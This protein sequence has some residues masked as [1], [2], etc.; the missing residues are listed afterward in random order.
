[1]TWPSAL[2]PAAVLA[3][4]LAGPS[5]AG[6]GLQGIWQDTHWGE[7]APELLHQFGARATQLPRAIDFGD[8]YVDVVLRRQMIGAVAMVVF[9]QMDKKTGGLKRIQIE[10]PRHAVNPPAFRA[11]LASLQGDFGAP[12]QTCA[13]P[14]RPAGGY[15]AGAEALWFRDGAVVS[16]IFRD[17]TLEAFEGCLFGPAYGSCGLKGQ[18]LVRIGPSD[19]DPDPCA[20]AAHLGTNPTRSR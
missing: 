11:L 14:A 1:V 6:A 8:S 20:L 10:R 5:P 7:T 4:T 15:Q 12:D 9:F 19:G 16:A 18:L 13:I 17:T 3:I 2:V